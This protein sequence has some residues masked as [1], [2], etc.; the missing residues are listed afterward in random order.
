MST[1]YLENVS[2]EIVVY[3]QP[4]VS[5][6]I[7]GVFPNNTEITVIE[8]FVGEECSFHYIKFDD[9]TV[10]Y[11]SIYDVEKLSNTRN[12]APF[13]CLSLRPNYAYRLPDWTKMQNG[14]IFFNELTLSYNIVVKVCYETLGDFVRVRK[15]KNDAICKGTKEL[16]ANLGKDNSDEKVLE[17]LN[18]FNFCEFIDYYLPARPLAKIKCLVAIDKKYIDA[19]PDV[20]SGLNSNIDSSFTLTLFDLNQKINYVSSLLD[21]YYDEARINLINLT[22]YLKTPTINTS[23]DKYELGSSYF[24]PTIENGIIFDLQDKS[25]NLKRVPKILFNALSDNNFSPSDFNKGDFL[26]IAIND[27]CNKIYDISFNKDGVCKRLTKFQQNWLK[28]DVLQDPTIIN[29]LKNLDKLY[30][31]E[32]CSVSL[33]AFCETYLY[34]KVILNFSQI[35]LN[36]KA[37]YDTLEAI[38]K[39]QDIMFVLEREYNSYIASSEEQYLDTLVQLKDAAARYKNFSSNFYI[40]KA[41]SEYDYSKVNETKNEINDSTPKEIHHSEP[42]DPNTKTSKKLETSNKLN[43][44]YDLLQKMGG[45]CKLTDFG[46]ACL[47]SLLSAVDLNSVITISTVKNFTLD[48]MKN[49][50]IPNIDENQQKEILSLLITLSCITKEKMLYLL[51]KNL[52]FDQYSNLNLENENYDNVKNTLIQYMLE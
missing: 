20:D 45:L 30:Q 15:L 6:D 19:I 25:K 21:S 7:V 44:V 35:P 36:E 48:E 32:R 41:S 24:S 11:C 26:E 46:F 49:K 14:E 37:N 43:S 5:C 22:F 17:Y 42:D 1:H 34:P 2:N 47:G 12:F 9:G 51:K 16:L 40:S 18:Y 50:I 52:D 39:V 27:K 38:Q 8:E 3:V 23:T 29:F 10:G 33:S 31:T 28:S 13:V 4:F